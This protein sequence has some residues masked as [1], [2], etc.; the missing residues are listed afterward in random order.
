MGLYNI[1]AVAGSGMSAQ[2]VRLNT[3]ASNL[4]N[5]DAAAGSPE[6][7]YRARQ[8]VFQAVMDGAIGG[9]EGGGVPVEVVGI[10]ESQAPPR[11]AYEPNSPLADA[12]GYVYYAN[13][14]PVEQMANMIS[15]SRSYQ[16]DVAVMNTARQLMERTLQLG[17][18]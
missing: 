1:F 18:Q 13:V 10:R 7:V 6:D 8:V 11:K 17:R 15:A 4:A 12:E 5:A 14:N 3:V 16:S 9:A 2:S